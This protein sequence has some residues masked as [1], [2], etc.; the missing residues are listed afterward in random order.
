MNLALLLHHGWT[1]S[2]RIFFIRVDR[3][4]IELHAFPENGYDSKMQIS[5]Y[6]FY[7][8]CSWCQPCI[9]YCYY[10]YCGYVSE[11]ICVL[12]M[13][14][15]VLIHSRSYIIILQQSH[16]P[17]R[18]TIFWCKTP[19]HGSKKERNHIENIYFFHD[20]ARYL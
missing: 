14:S 10:Y 16:A 19:N 18:T 9:T 13:C 6:H 5:D 11:L 2:S 3:V 20:H 8:K 1:R 12:E 15:G 17:S 4:E 7:R